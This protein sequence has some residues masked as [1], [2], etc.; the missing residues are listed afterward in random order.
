MSECRCGRTTRDD[1][2]V[3]DD[4]AD[5]LGRALGD[6]AWLDEEL[7]TTIGR[8]AGQQYTGG[9]RSAEVPLPVNWGASEARTHLHAMLVLW[10]R[11]CD[12]EGVRSSDPRATFPADNLTALSRW[13]LWRVDGLTLHD[14]G[15]EAVDEITS[16]VAHC[17]R[18]IDIPA[19]KH[20]MGT[21]DGCESPLWAKPKAAT[22][23]CR[24]CGEEFPTE[25]RREALETEAMDKLMD[26]LFTASEAALILCAHGLADDTDEVRLADRIRKW[27]KPREVSRTR[28][29]PPRLATKGHVR[30]ADQRTRPAYRLGDVRDLLERSRNTRKA[31]C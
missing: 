4:C 22:V 9:S 3:C 23:K 16:A 6:I 19:A 25:G 12:E 28:T 13:L 14:I 17:H 26:R 30:R 27:A 29:L 10:V 24:R 20:Y 8:Q 18:A 21:C 2:Y 11:F 7:E 15:S 5:K 1:A 31:A